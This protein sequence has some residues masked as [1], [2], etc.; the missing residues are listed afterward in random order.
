MNNIDF[1]KKYL[2]YKNKYINA[3]TNTL[4]VGGVCS[5]NKY[6]LLS[7]NE[8]NGLVDDII[9]LETGWKEGSSK[10]IEIYDHNQKILKIEKEFTSVKKITETQ[11]ETQ[12]DK[13]KNKETISNF[14]KFCKVNYED[15]YNFI[16]DTEMKETAIIDTFDNPKLYESVKNNFYRK[17]IV[18]ESDHFYRGYINWK[19]Y[20]DNTP[21]IKMN[22]E[23]VKRIRGG[24]V[25]FLAYFSFN[26]PNVTS[27]I[28]QLLFLNSLNHYGVS[29]I[30]I[31]LPYFPVG[32]MERIVGEGEVPTAYSLAHMLNMIPSG[33]SKNNL[34]I[35][36]IHA[37]CSRFFFHT[38]TRPVLIS[39]M[40]DFL[41][42]INKIS[43]DNKGTSII[44]FPDDGAK[45]RFEK[46]ID[47]AIKTVTCSKTRIGD[48]RKIRIDTG[49]EHFN[50]KEN[51]KIEGIINLFLID[52]L[53]QT[54][55]TLV[56]TFKGLYEQL[57]ELCYNLENV[58]CFAIVTH[59]IFPDESKTTKFF[60]EEYKS[61]KTTKPIKL[62]ITLITTNSRPIR[63][64]ELKE[65]CKEQV[66][67]INI[68]KALNDIFTKDCTTPYI[69]PY[70]IH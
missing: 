34:Y 68:S 70:S 67:L 45:K 53:V 6:V 61:L 3:I 32:T 69:A 25:I 27:I 24:K 57:D 55:G 38:N 54:G 19:T 4:Q 31:V 48:I 62:C 15:F 66:N 59:S 43:C 1:S 5:E 50:N 20:A 65:K 60:N 56:E 44:V 21:D 33:A 37:L 52:D 30:N 12:T 18:L 10:I 23:T 64:K 58:K 17:Q 11:T 42:E 9:K 16:K 8:F 47:P 49:L 28:T 46:L 35:F 51:K 40:P 14:V 39:M 63:T 29:E 7:C 41:T 26:E 13:E 22:A 2:K 36:D